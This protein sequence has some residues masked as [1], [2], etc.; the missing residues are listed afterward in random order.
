MK[1][2]LRVLWLSLCLIVPVAHA[3]SMTPVSGKDYELLKP[4]QATA[5]PKGKVEV[6]EF[7][8]YGCPHCAE[9]ESPLEA[10]ARKEGDKIALK[11]VPVAMNSALT[12]HSRMYYAL[13]ALGVSE[14]MM[15][16]LF[17]AIGQQ[18]QPLLT[19]QDQATF[20]SK[21]GVN[22]AQYLQTYYSARVQADVARAAKL[23]RDE[24]IVGVPTVTVAGK[25][26]TGPGYTG[27][28]EATTSVL[29]YLVK[30]VDAS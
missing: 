2:R 13:N 28:L 25:Y 6:T 23:I 11:R 9:F 27:S 12:P 16:I 5:A 15:P 3:A 29:D 1:H 8:W 20:L 4:A 24:R 17:D 26:E 22:R 30:Q 19:P 14:R 18:G 21:Y 7:F 10:W